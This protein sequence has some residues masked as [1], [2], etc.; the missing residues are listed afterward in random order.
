[1][2][3][4]KVKHVFWFSVKCNEKNPKFQVKDHVWLS[5]YKTIFAKGDTPN[6]SEEDFMTGN[7][8]NAVSW[9][10]LVILTMKKL[11]EHLIKKNCKTKMKQ[12]LEFRK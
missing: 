4:C 6:W 11:L 8:K 3:W 7:I 1:M 5:K 10:L 2:C 12:S 9:T